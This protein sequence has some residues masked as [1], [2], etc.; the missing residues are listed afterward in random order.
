MDTVEPFAAPDPATTDWV[1]IWNA[2]QSPAAAPSVRVHRTTQQVIPN[3]VWQTITFDAVRY[4]VGGPHWLAAQ[5]TRLTCKTAG[6]YVIWSS[7]TFSP[8]AGGTNRLASVWLNGVKYAGI[9]NST[10]AVVSTG[11]PFLTNTAL[12]QLIPGDYVE[13]Y[14]Y[15]DCGSALGTIPGGDYGMEF[16]MALVGGVP[17][18]PG[19]GVPNPIVEGQFIKG[20]GGAAIWAPV[21]QMKASAAGNQFSAAWTVAGRLEFWIDATKIAG[22]RPIADDDLAWHFVGAAGEPGYIGGWT[23]YAPGTYQGAG[24][25]RQGGVVFLTGLIAQGTVGVGCFV[26]PAGYRPTDYRRFAVTSN[27]AFGAVQIANDGT[28]ITFAGT[29]AWIDLSGCTFVAEQ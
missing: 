26:L 21:T 22:K 6:T 13:L 25:R 12:L 23:T 8:A 2:G 19:I 3:A 28:V 15:Q 4:D 27:S 9:G 14:V 16:G 20:S 11:Q 24:F 18:P 17:G 10:G 7:S 1:P 5:P 29:N